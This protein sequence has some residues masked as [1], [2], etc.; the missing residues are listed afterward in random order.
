MQRILYLL[1]KEFRQVFR[2]RAMIVIMFFIPIVQT[3]ILGSVMTTDV[4]NVKLII[5]DGDQSAASRELCRRF[6]HNPYFQM[7]GY[8]AGPADIRAALDKW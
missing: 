7:I 5:Y 2:D 6:M 1:Q 8:A 4:K 3:I